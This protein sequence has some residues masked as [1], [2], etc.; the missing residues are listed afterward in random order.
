MRTYILAMFNK[1]TKEYTRY[2][3]QAYSFNQAVQMAQKE[4]NGFPGLAADKSEGGRHGSF[5]A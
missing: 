3:C 2:Q 4:L 1:Q 5:N